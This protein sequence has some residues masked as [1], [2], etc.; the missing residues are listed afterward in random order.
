MSKLQTGHFNSFFH[1]LHPQLGHKLFFLII[2]SF[3][4]LQYFTKYSKC[5]NRPIFNTFDSDIKDATNTLD[6]FKKKFGLFG[7]SISQWEDLWSKRNK[8]IIEKATENLGKSLDDP[9]LSKKEVRK[10]KKEAK[11]QVGSLYSYARK[12][13]TENEVTSK[14][15]VT[16]KSIQPFMQSGWFE[17][18][19]DKKAQD[20]LDKLKAQQDAIDKMGISTDS[21]KLKWEEYFETADESEKWQ[22][23][24]V[25]DGKLV[26]T[27]LDD[28][29]IGQDNAAK[30]AKQHD[31]DLGNLTIGV[32]AANFAINA[33]K[34]ALNAIAMWGIMELIQLAIKG[35]DRLANA[36]LYASEAA[37]EAY[38]K[39]KENADASKQEIQSLDELI[40]KYKDLKTSATWGTSIEERT[41][42]ANIQEEI[43]ELVGSEANNLDL[44]NGKLDEQ[45]SKLTQIRNEQLKTN[46]ENAE[47]EYYTAVDAANKAV[48]NGKYFGYKGYDYVSKFLTKK[49]NAD[50]IKAAELL[51]SKYNAAYFSNWAANVR[52]AISD[53]IKHYTRGVFLLFSRYYSILF[54]N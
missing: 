28:I 43:V 45:I 12:Q 52:S 32:K 11:N 42:I 31:K 2:T 47:S 7:K 34:T 48:G 13:R 15:F 27:N 3:L 51:A 9:S 29:K 24:F 50:E 18:F 30:A 23:T 4:I 46:Y 49:N 26:A 39:S 8:N 19:D 25:K 22:K 17:N 41:E 20:I 33:F 16:K 54:S 35:V 14:F 37:N 36:A 1:V 6:I 21:A 53:L 5:V 44:V 38:N 40:Q 10:A